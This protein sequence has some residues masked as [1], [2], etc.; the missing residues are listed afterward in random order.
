MRASLIIIETVFELIFLSLQ[1]LELIQSQSNLSHLLA[2]Q[3]QQQRAIFSRLTIVSSFMIC[4]QVAFFFLSV[5]ENST[6]Q[7][8]HTLSLFRISFSSELGIFQLFITHLI[9][10]AKIYNWYLGVTKIHSRNFQ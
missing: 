1:Y 9:I 10:L 4:S 5:L 7:Y 3:E 2:L 8:T 6:Q